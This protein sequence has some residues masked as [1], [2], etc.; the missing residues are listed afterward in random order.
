MMQDERQNNEE[1]SGLDAP[2]K[3]GPIS[4]DVSHL[5]VS[6]DGKTRSLTALEGHILNFLA[7]QV[8]TVCTV[9]QINS[10]VLGYN[11][12]ADTSLIKSTIRHL[13]Q[14]IEPDPR[15]P[16]YILTVPDVG[17]TLVSHDL[18]EAKQKPST[19]TDV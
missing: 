3:V 19:D 11:N 9:S 7:V 10:Q 4:V 5:Q 16:I 12:D 8:D 17:Y 15:N 14:K 18:V 1:T 13:R 6:V 2:I